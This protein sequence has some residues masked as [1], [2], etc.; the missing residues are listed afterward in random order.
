MGS[1][2]EV[3]DLENIGHGTILQIQILQCLVKMK[4]QW[5]FEGSFLSVKAFYFYSLLA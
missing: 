3:A 4:I 1:R 5:K 2:K